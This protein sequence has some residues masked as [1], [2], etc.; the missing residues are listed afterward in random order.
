MIQE[1]RRNLLQ[2]VAVFGDEFPGMEREST[3]V[4]RGPYSSNDTFPPV[5]RSPIEDRSTLM[6]N[7]SRL[8]VFFVRGAQRSNQECCWGGM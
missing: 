6:S 2:I 5:S 7:V 1:A 8:R 4:E 3:V